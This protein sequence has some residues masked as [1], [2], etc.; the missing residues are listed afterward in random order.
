VPLLALNAAIFRRIFL[1]LSVILGLNLYLFEGF[2]RNIP[3]GEQWVRM[4]PG[5]DIT[6]LVGLCN[7]AFFMILI[8]TRNWWFDLT[9]YEPLPGQTT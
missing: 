7:V 6:I 4:L 1:A 2:G 5:F 3:A 8:F 9:A